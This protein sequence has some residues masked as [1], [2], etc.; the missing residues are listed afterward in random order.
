MILLAVGRSGLL[1]AVQPGWADWARGALAGCRWFVV[2]YSCLLLWDRGM[3]S[4]TVV[5]SLVV[6][7]GD[8]WLGSS[9][10]GRGRSCW[11]LVGVSAWAAAQ[12]GGLA[13]SG[14]PLLAVSGGL[15]G[16]AVQSG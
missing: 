6:G 11:L 2:L 4:L 1:V 10:L 14:E 5:R 8:S 13:G 12:P 16:V 9:L 7:P 15:S 3:G